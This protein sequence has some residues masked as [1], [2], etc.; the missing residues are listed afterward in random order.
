MKAIQIDRHGG[1]EVLTYRDVTE[2]QPGPGEVQV[3]VEASGVN[4]ID[5]YRREGK[6]KVELPHIPGSEAAGTVTAVGE[7][8]SRFQ[9]GDRVAG[10]SLTGSYAELLTAPQDRLVHVPDGVDSQQAAAAMLQGMTAHYLVNDTFKLS[11]GHT[12]LVHAAAGGVGLLLVQMA[13]RKGATVI[14]TV[15]TREKAERAR[16]A[17]ADHVILYTEQDFVGEVT[18]LV[19]GGA[20]VVYDS[21]GNTTFHGSLESLK[22]RGMLV[23]FGQSSGAVEPLDPGATLIKGSWFLTRPS[24]FHHIDTREELEARAA[25]VLGQ[26]AAEE[27]HLRIDSVL[28]LAQAAE[29]HRRL[30]ARESSGKLLLEP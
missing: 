9:P 6:Y 16:Q 23:L 28:P 30:A 4:F 2:Q 11:R 14:G 29:A 8:V 10:A 26:V 24:L 25:D 13:K 20:D 19:G 22:R 5:I 27:L 17:G 12:C 3:R 1:I 18:R 7:G 15:S 21:V